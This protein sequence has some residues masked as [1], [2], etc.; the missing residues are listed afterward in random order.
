MISTL[1]ITEQLFIVISVLIFLVLSAFF[2]GA[3][4]ALFSLSRSSLA[5]MEK[6][7]GRQR[8]LAAL[9]KNPRM[10]LVT[11]LFGNLL[12]NIANTS[13][14][15]VLSIRIF[16]D[17]GIGFAMVAMA[18]LILVVGE[19]TPKSIAMKHSATI[20]PA[21]APVLKFFMVLF[22]P[23]RLLLGLIADITVA[24]SRSLFGT[25]EEEYGSRELA[26][27]VE[28]AHRDGLFDEFES[29]ILTNLFH[30]TETAL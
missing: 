16:G 5:E 18:F 25:S 8:R 2:S 27:A 24:R 15:T 23:A 7:S 22:T 30:F 3:E 29:R 10:L 21:I 17:K 26:D 20:A 4:T 13:M 19:I 12:V 14:V 1:D 6:G 28:V 9:M 11:I